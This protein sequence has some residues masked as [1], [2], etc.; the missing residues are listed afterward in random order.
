MMLFVGHYNFALSTLSIY[1]IYIS[2]HDY[3]I[4]KCNAT[5]PE[6]HL[7]FQ[8]KERAAQAGFEP[9]HTAYEADALP[10]E[11]PRHA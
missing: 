9:V 6:Q 3:S 11:L 10:T 5:A 1:S 2:L 7:F 8:G 4:P